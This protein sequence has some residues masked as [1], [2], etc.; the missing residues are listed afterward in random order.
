MNYDLDN[1]ELIAK[2]LNSDRYDQIGVI[3]RAQLLDDVLDFA[4]SGWVTYKVALDVTNYLSR[5]QHYLPW[6]TALNNLGYINKMTRTT[7]AYG[8]FKVSEDEILK[9]ETSS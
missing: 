7:P 8:K 6:L 4:R 5:E 1:W 2:Q 9:Y 3:N